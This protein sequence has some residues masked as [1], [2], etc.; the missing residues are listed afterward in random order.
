MAWRG[1]VMVCLAAS[2]LFA[3]DVLSVLSDRCFA[4]HGP[5]AAH[6]MAGLRLDV[7]GGARAVSAKL[8]ERI[9][10]SDPA[11]RMPPAYSGKPALTAREVESIRSW[12]QAGAP[13]QKFW[14]LV[15]PKRPA[16]AA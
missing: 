13:M 14:S 9:S 10:A 5:D 1:A 2:P 6:R 12:I 4:C 15:Q 11:K 7:D 8:L 16:G 3:Q